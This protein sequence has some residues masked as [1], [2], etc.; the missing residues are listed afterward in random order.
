LSW[1]IACVRD[2]IAELLAILNILMASTGPSPLLAVAVAR[3][4]STA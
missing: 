3:P 4:E 2:L 1:L